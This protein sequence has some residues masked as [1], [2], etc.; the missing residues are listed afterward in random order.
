[1]D[2]QGSSADKLGREV[3][4]LNIGANLKALTNQE[5]GHR[6]HD[7]QILLIMK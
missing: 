1:M 3:A 4:E 7:L 5:R 2:S 6:R